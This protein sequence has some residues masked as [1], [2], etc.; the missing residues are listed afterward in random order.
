MRAASPC[1]GCSAGP[2]A[3]PIVSYSDG[4]PEIAFIK[5]GTLDDTSWIKP[6]LEIWC[7]T[8]QPWVAHRPRP[9]R[10]SSRNPP[11]RA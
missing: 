3:R 4:L 11:S 8:A 5:A 6:T 9:P 1:S 2:A 7:E 10:A